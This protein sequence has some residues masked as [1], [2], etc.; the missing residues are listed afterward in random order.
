V[1]FHLGHRIHI[2]EYER[3]NAS[4][5]T[6]LMLYPSY[7]SWPGYLHGMQTGGSMKRGRKPAASAVLLEYLGE[8]IDY[9]R[10]LARCGMFDPAEISD[11]VK[12]LIH[13]RMG[14]DDWV[15]EIEEL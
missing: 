3:L 5:I 4:S 9:R 1:A 13:N 11:W 7:T 15:F 2:V 14:P 10:A 6:Q 8:K 12:R